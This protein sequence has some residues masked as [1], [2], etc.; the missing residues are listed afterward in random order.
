MHGIGDALGGAECEVVENEQH[1]LRIRCGDVLFTDLLREMIARR[2]AAE[3]GWSHAVG[4]ARVRKSLALLHEEPARAWT[5]DAL[6][7]SDRT[8]EQIAGAVGYQD[9]FSFSKALKRDVGVSPGD[10]RRR[11]ASEREFP[12]R[13]RDGM[14]RARVP[15]R[16]ARSTRDR[17]VVS[18]L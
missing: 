6:A 4:D 10:F 7:G 15:S 2:G 17:S 11:D 18:Q 5:L 1:E 3:T 14:T 12:W 9:A 8:L 13:F 16:R